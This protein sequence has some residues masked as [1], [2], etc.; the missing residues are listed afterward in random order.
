M[1][2]SVINHIRHKLSTSW[3]VVFIRLNDEKIIN[4]KFFFIVITELT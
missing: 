1:K 4:F 3:T 2:A